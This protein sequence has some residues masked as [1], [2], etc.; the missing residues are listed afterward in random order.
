M[1]NTSLLRL[2]KEEYAK[3]LLWRKYQQCPMYWLEHRFAENP[4]SFAWSLWG[5]DYDKHDWDGDKD[6]LAEAWNALANGDWV[7][8]ESATGTGKTFW[9][10]RIVFWFLDCFENSLVVTTAPKESQ[11]KLHLWTE[12]ARAFNKFKRIRENAELLSLRLIV[13]ASKSTNLEDETAGWQAIGFVAGVGASEDSATKAQ[14]F[15][16][17]H[18]LIIIEETP[19][20]G[21]PIMTAFQNTSTGGHNLMLAVG[22]PDSEVDALH[23]FCQSNSV[24]P[25][26]VSALDFPNIVLNDEVVKGAVTTKSIERRK[27]DYG[28]DSNLYKSR[29]RGESPAQSV[30]SLIKLNW[31]NDICEPQYLHSGEEA[32]GIDVAN[33]ENGD[34]AAVA[35]GY[36]N[37]LANLSQFQCPNA[38]HLAYNF[39]YDDL[40]LKEKDYIVYKGIPKTLANKSPYLQPNHIGVDAV[41]VGVSTVN[42]FNEMLGKKGNVVS[43]QGGAIKEVIPTDKEGKPLYSFGSLRAQMYWQLREDIRL[44]KI[45]FGLT[46]KTILKQ[47]IQ[48]LVIPKFVAK[49]DKIEVESKE[50]IKKRLGHSPN[51]ADAVVYWN[52]VRQE[53]T[54]KKVNLANLLSKRV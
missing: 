24:R 36:G 13:D 44:G 31:I 39:F 18:M 51:L 52:W 21:F 20:V 38:S 34:K 3:R 14:G 42:A 15:H 25:F 40:I 4:K 2:A 50:N 37:V 12:I 48:E 27:E 28:E 29:V 49:G 7:G 32:V 1:S 54:K 6:P 23:S 43:L 45:Q 41:G 9:L 47:L 22:N 8:V 5:A 10:A 46:D 35:H 53:H 33:S 19:G 30:D 26:R 16:R 17:E 11:L